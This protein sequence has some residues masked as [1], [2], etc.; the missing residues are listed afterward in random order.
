MKIVTQ[1]GFLYELD[2]NKEEER[3]KTTG[4]DCTDFIDHYGLYYYDQITVNLDDDHEFF[5]YTVFGANN[6]ENMIVSESGYNIYHLY[7]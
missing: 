2:L 1:H 3:T 7:A 5:R 6:K 4:G